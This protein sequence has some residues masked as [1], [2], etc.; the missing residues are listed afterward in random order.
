MT[1]MRRSHATFA[2]AHK[3]AICGNRVCTPGWSMRRRDLIRLIA[4]VAVA[5][6][7]TTR[8][9]E[10][11]KPVIG[12]LNSGLPGGGYP[13]ISAF[14]KG[15]GET[16]FVEGRDVLIEYRWA[17]GHYERLPALL[18]DLVQKK[19]NV[20]AA[21]STPAALAAKV[22]T[23]TIPVVFTTSGD[24]VGFGLVSSLNSPDGNLTGA[25]QLNVEVAQKRLELMHEVIPAAN[26]IA[27]LVNPPNPLAP[28][29]SKETNAAADALGLKLQIVR[30][31]SGQDLATVFESLV[32]L[33]AEALVI[34]SDAFF[35]SRSEELAQLALDHRM[36][37]IYEYPQFTAAGGLMSYGG[38]VAQSYHL[39]G[40]YVGRI[41]KGEKPRDLPVQRSTKVELLI[42]LKSAKTLGITV[43]ISL[44]GRAD[45][46]IE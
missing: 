22:A 26:N 10:P 31:G 41:L 4:G 37:A 20:I 8:A 27:L 34:V 44:L 39:A 38:D 29:I 18:A 11:A 23:A 43:P 1:Q 16:G 40:I 5:W 17:E 25:T 7:V 9:Q 28:P 13:P 3:T 19:V 24:P 30:A 45:E 46:V 32:Q 15:L 35:S 33:K 36:P 14:L 12:F 2:E 6:P 21:T 42:N